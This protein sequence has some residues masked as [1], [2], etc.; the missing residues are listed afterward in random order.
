M[1]RCRLFGHSWAHSRDSFP[2]CT[3]CGRYWWRGHAVQIARGPVLR[4][5]VNTAERRYG[6]MS[7]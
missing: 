3:T 6:G 7:A 1:I 4:L 5:L 2:V